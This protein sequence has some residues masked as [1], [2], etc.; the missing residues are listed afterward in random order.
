[1]RLAFGCS[2]LDPRPRLSPR[3]AL[4]THDADRRFSGSGAAQRF[5]QLRTDARTHSRASDPR[6]STARP[7]SAGRA[8]LLPLSVH[9]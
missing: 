3:L 9:P 5:L 4:I 1:L 8:N 6:D 7:L 2:G